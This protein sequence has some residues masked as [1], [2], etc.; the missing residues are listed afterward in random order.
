MPLVV[1]IGGSRSG[2]SEAAERLATDAGLPVLYVATSVAADGEMEE[3]IAQHRSR[4]PR[5]WE[6]VESPDPLAALEERSGR[7][8]LVDSLGA[9]LSASMEAHG[10]VPGP[11]PEA[12]LGPEGQSARE[13]VLEGVRSFAARAA[14]RAELTLV[15]AEEVGSGPVAQSTAGRRFVDLMGEATQVLSAATSRAILVVA[16]RWLELSSAPH[17]SSAPPAPEA[18]GLRF[19]GDGVGRESSADHAVSVV[20]EEP[21]G[22]LSRALAEGLRDA[23][24]YPDEREAREAIARRH[25][26]SPE[27]VVLTNGA[28]EGFWLLASALRPHHAVCVH[29][30]YTE[31]ELALRTAG[32]AVERAFRGPGFALEPEAVS[33]GADLV[34]V[35]NPSNPSGRLEPAASLAALARPGRTLVVDE[36]FA[37]LVPGEP[38][39]LAGRTE[40]PGLVVVRSLTKLWSLPGVRAGYLL[41]PPGLARAIEEARPSWNV[42]AVALRALAECASRAGEGRE[43]AERVAEA[44]SALERGLGRL[45]GIE[46]WPSAANFV[47]LRAGGGEEL[48]GRL[49]ARGIAVRPC[50]SFP[51]LDSDHLRAAVRGPESNRELLDALREA[52][53]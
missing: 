37:E 34:I 40:L 15:V 24:R 38:E 43:R 21:P 2:K 41:A 6:T 7:T 18:P 52:L 51:G 32:I 8:V 5:H 12:P 48:K 50:Q 42:N 29:P 33:P 31:P 11:E 30:S 10:L 47:L 22:W 35:D 27:E 45:E 49:L 23:S 14:E 26:R 3:R 25:G 16:G 20:D 46:T 39:S 13:A 9:W 4:R 53:A 17:A 28:N 19:H 1:V 44:R 36:S